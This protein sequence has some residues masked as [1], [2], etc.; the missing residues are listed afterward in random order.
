LSNKVNRKN[1]LRRKLASKKIH[2][3]SKHH[4]KSK[5]KD[6]REGFHCESKSGTCRLKTFADAIYLGSLA[7][8]FLECSDE[9]SHC[10][11]GSCICNIG[12]CYD[13]EQAKCVAW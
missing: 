4:S 10:D 6:T 3:K 9:N 13:E 12:M 2:S 11:T 8:S 5:T 7:P 1:E